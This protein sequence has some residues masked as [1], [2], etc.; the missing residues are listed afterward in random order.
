MYEASKNIFVVMCGYPFV[1]LC[2]HVS[3][4]FDV[5]RKQYGYYCTREYSEESFAVSCQKHGF[6]Y[7]NVD[8]NICVWND[9]GD[10]IEISPDGNVS[11]NGEPFTIEMQSKREHEKISKQRVK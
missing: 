1:H 9:N 7:K 4:H 11:I 10:R 5:V 3:Q 6:Q 2:G 8:G